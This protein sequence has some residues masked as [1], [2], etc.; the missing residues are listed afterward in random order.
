VCLSCCAPGQACL[1]CGAGERGT[2][3]PIGCRTQHACRPSIL[4]VCASRRSLLQD[5]AWALRTH[6]ESQ[7]ELQRPAQVPRPMRPG[8]RTG[9]VDGRNLHAERVQAAALALVRCDAVVHAQRHHRR[10]RVQRRARVAQAGHRH[11]PAR[12][13][14]HAPGARGMRAGSRAARP[15]AVRSERRPPHRLHASCPGWPRTPVIPQCTLP[16]PPGQPRTILACKP[17]KPL[18]ARTR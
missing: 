8:A 10:A 1:P 11:Q 6:C 5:T 2:Q 14:A 15:S 18:P 7:R 3:A 16:T 13:R 9:N 4:Q 12:L 17:D